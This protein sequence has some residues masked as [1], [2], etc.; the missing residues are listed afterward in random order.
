MSRPI[1]ITNCVDTIVAVTAR[2]VA[3]ETGR[4]VSGA[5]PISE[6]PD[7]TTPALVDLFERAGL[8]DTER[9]I[10]RVLL[11]AEV[12]R[13]AYRCLLRLSSD[14][15]HAGVS[16][17]ALATLAEGVGRDPTAILLAIR[18]D[19]R[20]FARGLIEV[21]GNPAHPAI[22]RR[23][24]LPAHL[25]D[26]VVAGRAP[27]ALQVPLVRHEPARAVGSLC[28]LPERGTEVNLADAILEAF[29]DVLAGRPLWLVGPRG[30][31]KKTTLAAVAHAQGYRLLALAFRE[32]VRVPPPQLVATLWREVL[33]RRAIIVVHDVDDPREVVTSE[34]GE[35]AARPPSDAIPLVYGWLVRAG[36]P[37]V[38][39]SSAPPPLADLELGSPPERIVRLA[40]P[41]PT[42]ALALWRECLP[43]VTDEDVT[44]LEQLAS[45]FRLVPGRI[46]Q[47]TDEARRIAGARGRITVTQS[48]LT[49]AISTSVAQ[50]VSILGTLVEDT[51]TWED[52]VLPRETLDSV[53]ELIAR[54]RHRHQVLER[55]GFR[56]KMSKGLGLAA[57]FG[58]P[59]GTGK[60]MV[61]SLIAKE[62]GQELYQ[63]DL[64]RVVSKWIGETEKNLAKVF[65]AAEGANVL[66]LF[67]EADALFGKRTEVSSSNDRHANSE[68]NYLLQRVER[69]EGVCILTTNLE[70][71][72]DTAF[73][74]R[75]AFRIN[76]E[77]PDE[78]ERALLWRRMLPA[79][80]DVATDLDFRALARDYELAGGNIRNAV[81]RAA[82]LAA[83]E[84]RTIDME[85][86]ER[87]VRLEYRDAGKLSA[88]GRIT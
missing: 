5:P 46:V 40:A 11:A 50:Q 3:H 83:S 81:L 24:S 32:A 84:E 79:S 58:G 52:I 65:D 30:L 39:T 42:D 75:L 16:V 10:V 37:V 33:I 38:F 25:V 20:L 88:D 15:T 28:P 76:F 87:A 47:V 34:V 48:D 53:R 73:K 69:F 27:A 43:T 56:R 6:P 44:S 80:A 23:L 82:F 41:T 74:R 72:I 17:D 63:I 14:P 7:A 2:V 21:I 60:T 71:S 12:D 4:D 45:Q 55:W 70:G 51:Q 18:P 36:L 68:I 49:R 78:D 22:V 13:N 31:G 67:D 62:L 9:W 61:A 8:D 77:I 54:V 59:P 35:V 19:A 85:L 1:D 26:L 57:L 66:L 29:P 86:L 64:S